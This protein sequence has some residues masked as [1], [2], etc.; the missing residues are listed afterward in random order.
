MASFGPPDRFKKAASNR[1]TRP[2]LTFDD[3]EVDD[4]L[5]G[6]I[7]Q[8]ST[9]KGSG[10]MSD[11]KTEPQ[12][13]I[14]NT[15]DV[16]E[17]TGDNNSLRSDERVKKNDTTSFQDSDSDEQEDYHVVT[18]ASLKKKRKN[19]TKGLRSSLL[20]S[21]LRTKLAPNLPGFPSAST[22]NSTTYSKS[23]L[24][25]L[26][27]STPTTPAEYTNSGKNVA[28][29]E[30]MEMVDDSLYSM[31]T[32][33]S[34]SVGGMPD[35][36]LI[37]HLIERRRRKAEVPRKDDFVSLDEEASNEDVESN[38]EGVEMYDK[39]QNERSSRLQREDDIFD[40]E[41]E[42]LAEGSDGRIPLSAAQEAEQKMQRRRDME[43]LINERED[44]EQEV[45]KEYLYSGGDD[46]GSDSGWEQAQIQKGAFGSKAFS[47]NHA[48]IGSNGMPKQNGTLEPSIMVL[49]E[50]PDL[51]SVIKRL[52]VVLDSMR[53]QRDSHLKL[54]EE[55]NTQKDEIEAREKEVKE[56]LSAAPF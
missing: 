44:E 24:D 48:E 18:A 28:E 17:I 38:M 3:E 35:E 55:F 36:A 23:Y 13:P 29:Q 6:S 39:H 21:K 2:K 42:M 14:G 32:A 8:A 34:E 30:D 22:A 40:N 54:L 12:P 25:E 9:A 26:R 51:E 31:D 46:S 1:R 56:A 4:S 47:I 37:N 16:G 5:N 41:Y 11:E 15:K 33:A 43:E 45:G 53:E 20:N 27:D 19:N 7:I 52:T 10:S 49:Q 50:L